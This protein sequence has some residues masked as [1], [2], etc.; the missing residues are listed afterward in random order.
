MTH[1]YKWP[2]HERP[3]TF[4]CKQAR[5][6]RDS[7]ICYH[8][9]P[10]SGRILLVLVMVSCMAFSQNVSTPKALVDRLINDEHEYELKNSPETATY[11]G[12]HRYDDQVS[13][14]SINA[15]HARTE[16]IK[17]FLKRADAIDASKLDDQDQLNLKLLSRSL[18][19]EVESAPLEPWT[20]MVSQFGGPHIGYAEM[21]QST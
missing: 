17:G 3:R 20:M 9:R 18:R 13:D 8:S 2:D 21:G 10:M 19:D 4:S 1:Q 12:D 14:L 7:S 5:D 16:A 15:F 11:Q 6:M